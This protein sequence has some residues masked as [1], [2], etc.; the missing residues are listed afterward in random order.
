MTGA[1][2]SARQRAKLLLITIAGN[3]NYGQV[4]RMAGDACHRA[5][6]KNL[7]TETWSDI[8]KFVR[9]EILQQK[10]ICPVF[11]IPYSGTNGKS[12]TGEY[13]PSLDRI[14]STK[15]YIFN[16]MQVISLKANRA[17]NDL[18][19]EE[20]TRLFIHTCGTKKSAISQIR[21]S[22]R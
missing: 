16:N 2:Y 18:T 4:T 7:P 9:D 6:K 20:Q 10:G 11:N 15:G 22:R 1:E 5:K 3:V 8:R 17:K 19:P 21:K 13:A 14:D 12:S